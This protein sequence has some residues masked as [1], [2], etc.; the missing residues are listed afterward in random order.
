VKQKQWSFDY[1]K[2]ELAVREQE[3]ID[4]AMEF[5]RWRPW[6][7]YKEKTFTPAS[8][9]KLREQCGFDWPPLKYALVV[10][11]LDIYLERSRPRRKDWDPHA[12]LKS[13]SRIQ[14]QLKS[15]VLEII[16]ASREGDSGMLGL[17]SYKLNRYRA[18]ADLVRTPVRYNA[19]LPAGLLAAYAVALL[20]DPKT[21]FHKQLKICKHCERPLFARST[22][23][24]T[25]DR[26]EDCKKPARDQYM[27]PERR[28]GRKGKSARK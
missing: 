26:H 19:E 20:A 10:D 6:N 14:D 28:K 24:R 16:Q 4:R 27:T 8:I 17:L 21:G 25:S 5:A 13:L 23:G 1:E 9:R 15:A 7:T 22:G 3:I 2:N 11:D 12:E 18:I